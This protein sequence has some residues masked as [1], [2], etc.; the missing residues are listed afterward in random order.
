MCQQAHGA[1][2]AT[3]ARFRREDVHYAQGQ[4]QLSEF[5]SS[6]DVMRKFCANCG[7]NIEWGTIERMPQW[8]AIAV[9]S[10]EQPFNY[11]TI[12]NLHLDSS[13]CWLHSLPK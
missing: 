9:A 4:D 12:K 2:F 1:A 5:R 11:P 6:S 3:Y 8:V 10:L 13:A 7:S